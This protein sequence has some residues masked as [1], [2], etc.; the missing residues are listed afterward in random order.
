MAIKLLGFS[1]LAA[2]LLQQPRAA[3]PHLK[4]VVTCHNGKRAV[5]LHHILP[6]TIGIGYFSSRRIQFFTPTLFPL[7]A[8]SPAVTLGVSSSCRPEP[9]TRR[10]SLELRVAGYTCTTRRVRAMQLASHAWKAVLTA[11]GL[12]ARQLSRILAGLSR[13]PVPQL[14]HPYFSRS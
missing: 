4:V 2:G 6:A 7:C 8:V 11:V 3:P 5:R 13:L 1:Y 12:P 10:T 9:L 14:L